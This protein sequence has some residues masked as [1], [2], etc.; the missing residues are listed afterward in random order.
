M[1]LN[2]RNFADGDIVAVHEMFVSEHVVRGTM[3]LP[4]QSMQMTEKRLAAAAGVFRL[5]AMRGEEVV[6]FCELITYPD[7]PRRRHAGELNMIITAE[8]WQGK[9]VGRAMMQAMIDLADKWLC[10]TRLGLMV[11]ATNDHAIRLYEH[12]GFS[13]EG[14]MPAYAVGDGGLVDAIVMGRVRT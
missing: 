6:G 12:F 9:G 2:I 5:V 1:D 3:R 8:L 10:L 11:W 13:I 14:R 7:N 4:Y